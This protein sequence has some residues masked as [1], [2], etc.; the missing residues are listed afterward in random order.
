M[1]VLAASIAVA[2]AQVIEKRNPIFPSGKTVLECHQGVKVS[3]KNKTDAPLGRRE[4]TINYADSITLKGVTYHRFV[5]NVLGYPYFAIVNDSVMFLTQTDNQ[6]SAHKVFDFRAAE[7]TPW[8]YYDS[9]TKRTG[10]FQL[11]H[12]GYCPDLNDS[13]YAF[14]I[15]LT[16]GVAD[17]MRLGIIHVAYR[18]GIVAL[19]YFSNNDL[20]CSCFAPPVTKYMENYLKHH[21][22]CEQCVE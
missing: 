7:N 22:K 5:S 2:Q 11:L 15:K 10:T 18:N 8:Q 17:G 4:I 19:Q 13:I 6:F 12:R 9:L 20:Y 16:P 1:L 21:P 14:S 3:A